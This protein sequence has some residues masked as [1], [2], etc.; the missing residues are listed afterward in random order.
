MI[1]INSGVRSV[2]HGGKT[3]IAFALCAMLIFCSIYLEIFYEVGGFPGGATHLGLIDGVISVAVL[4]RVALFLVLMAVIYAIVFRTPAWVKERLFRWRYLIAAFIL[5]AM[6]LFEI[7]FSSVAVWSSQLVGG[8][9][10]G[11]LFGIPRAI[12]SDEFNN[13]LLW[14]MSQAHNDYMPYSDILRGCTTD[15]RLLYN[16]PSW[17]LATL[18]RP[19]LW[20]YLLFGSTRG[21]AF[22]WGV[23][24]LASFLSSFELGR[25]I[26]DDR[27]RLSLVFAFIS[28]FSPIA[29]WFGFSDIIIFG[30]LLVVVFNLYLHSRSMNQACVYSITIAW[31]CGCYILTLY[32]AWMVPF[33]YIFAFLGIYLAFGNYVDSRGLERDKRF[34]PSYLLPMLFAVICS[35]ACVAF[36]LMESRDVLAATASTV[37]PGARFETGGTARHMLFEYGYSLFFGLF[38]PATASELSGVFSL[39][40][41]GTCCAI[42]ASLKNRTARFIPFI[43]LQFLFVLYASVG[44]PRLLAQMTLLYNTP[45]FRMDWPVGY[46]ETVLLIISIAQVQG[47][48]VGEHA[49]RPGHMAV[50]TAI[51]ILAAMFFTFFVISKSSISVPGFRRFIFDS[52]LFI[53]IFVAALSV[54]VAIFGRNKKTGIDSFAITV[55]SIIGVVSL[56]VNPI[57]KGVAPVTDSPIAKEISSIVSDNPDG[58]W[59][60][61]N[62]WVL[63]NLCT[64]LGASTYFSTNAY[65][66]NQ[67]WDIVDPDGMNSDVYNRYCHINVNLFE[68]ENEFELNQA[69]LVSVSLDD[70][71]LKSLNADYI[72]TRERLGAARARLLGLKEIAHTDGYRVYGRG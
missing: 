59:V 51:L 72:L 26:T 49:R 35:A 50:R 47:I 24:I 23:R 12:R 62:S 66:A 28:T 7:S 13:A 27:R 17:S 19:Q 52:L 18:F 31:L 2:W 69:D 37:Y 21:L 5:A 33:F 36:V 39:F 32:P 48:R 56:C 15:T 45:A 25:I 42:Y 30:Q 65:P 38:A 29:L 44:F 10:D 57:Q 41:L 1:Q 11:L 67:I 6:V 61:D 70:E 34:R 40:P 55:I 53:A 54:F 43:V 4:I 58:K 71:T 64:G 60:V 14:N 46:L 22:H 9:S 8:T 63:S 16:L 68:D 3:L 20:G